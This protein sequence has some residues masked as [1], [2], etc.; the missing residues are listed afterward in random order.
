MNMLA[1]QSLG[2]SLERN[3]WGSLQFFY[4]IWL[5]DLF[6]GLIHTFLAGLLYY[7]PIVAYPEYM[8]QC[9]VGFSSILFALMTIQ[10]HQSPSDRSLFGFVNI[11]GKI[12]PWV[13]LVILQLIMP[14]ISF[15]GHLSGIL[16]AYLCNKKIKKRIPNFSR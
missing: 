8:Y 10:V 9:T 7:N 3:F 2:P 6:C 12:Y 5:F 11:P 15:L 14:G 4:L 13:L 1:L 16:V